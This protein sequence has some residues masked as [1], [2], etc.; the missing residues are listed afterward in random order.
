MSSQGIGVAR[1]AWVK[2]GITC[3]LGVSF[4]VGCGEAPLHVE[5][6]NAAADGQVATSAQRLEYGGHTYFFSSVTRTWADAQRSCAELGMGL[7]T[8]NDSVEDQWLRAQQP[9]G[10]WWLGYNDRAVE[11]TWVWSDGASTYSNWLPGEPNNVNNEDCATTHASQFGWNDVPCTAG[12][13][14]VCESFDAPQVKHYEGHEY[15]FFASPRNWADA[16]KSCEQVGYSL[17]TV[18]DSAEEAWLKQQMP[19][20]SVWLGYSDSSVE[21]RWVWEDGAP[22][23]TNWRPGE[24]NNSLGN[25]DCAVN[26]SIATSTGPAGLWNDIPCTDLAAYVCES[27]DPGTVTYHYLSFT[28]SNTLSA[29]Q[30]TTDVSVFLEPGQVL[31]VGTCGVPGA[32]ATDDTFLRLVGPD[33][34][35]IFFNDDA[36][37]GSG[38]HIRYKVPECG[39]GTYVIKA[40]CY[41][42]GSC[43][44][45][46]GYTH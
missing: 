28:A 10:S 21:G 40:G 8:I 2:S 34:E 25:E 15:I 19:W 39:G 36:C 4:T 14:F 29:T 41:E 16:Q 20:R 24:P 44:G 45:R 23:Y 43:G 31:S 37:K 32:F 5:E 11:G 26:N 30:S 22:T 9:S 18:N 7:M 42:S 27:R 38:S 13:R 17:V 46:L 12:Y 6:L 33:G 3:L 35:E 1:S